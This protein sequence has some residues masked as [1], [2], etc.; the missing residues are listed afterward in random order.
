MWC[1]FFFIFR[2]NICRPKDL[3]AKEVPKGAASAK[4]EI[5]PTIR[6]LNN[7]Y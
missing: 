2:S 3:T 4:E 7:L 6:I 5:E 1:L